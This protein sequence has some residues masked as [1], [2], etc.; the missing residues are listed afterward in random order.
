MT[1]IQHPAAREERAHLENTLRIIAA[2]QITADGELANA[3]KEL[4]DIFRYDRDNRD[5]LELRQLLFERAEQTVR[6]LAASRLRPYFT[7]INF[8]EECGARQV[9]YIGKHSVMKPD[10]LEVE[11]ID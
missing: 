3:K 11:V 4:A 7:R 1:D 9:Y 6:N 8:T 10:D 5:M 2:Q